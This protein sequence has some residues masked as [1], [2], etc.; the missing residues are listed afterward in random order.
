MSPK[1]SEQLKDLINNLLVEDPEQ[2]L[3]TLNIDDLKEHSFF[4]SIDWVEYQNKTLKSP[5]KKVIEKY[6][7]KNFA[8]EITTGNVKIFRQYHM[9]DEFLLNV[10]S[11][12]KSKRSLCSTADRVSNQCS[13]ESI[14]QN[15]L[16]RTMNLASRAKTP[17]NR[18]KS[19]SFGVGV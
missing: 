13:S 1:G 2:R 11:N 14:G 18:K 19:V 17:K 12:L 7:L 3:G 4:K 15:H 16:Y 10:E 9:E 6:P 8:E 5:L